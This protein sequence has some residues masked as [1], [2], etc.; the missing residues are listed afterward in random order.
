[1]QQAEEEQRACLDAL[2]ERGEAVWR[3]VEEEID[4][5]DFHGYE[6][7]AAILNDLRTLAD[8][9]GTIPRFF[10]RLN[11]LRLRHARKRRFIERLAKFYG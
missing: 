6:R 11:T 8:E 4:K 1:M 7:A 5:R 3:E 10:K 9:A 2:L